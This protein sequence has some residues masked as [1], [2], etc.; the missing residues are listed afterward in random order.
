MDKPLKILVVDDIAQIRAL[1]R[2]G[3]QA[4][5]SNVEITEAE[6]LREARHA[7]Q[8]ASFDAIITDCGF[9]NETEVVRESGNRNGV[10]LINE[11]RQRK[12]GKTNA[13]APIAFNSAE[14]TPAKESGALQPG[15][16]TKCFKKGSLYGSLTRG[17]ATNNFTV[18]SVA[19]PTMSWLQTELTEEKVSERRKS[20]E[21]AARGNEGVSFLSRFFGVGS[22][23]NR[24]SGK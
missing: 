2:E 14:I 10:V 11:I 20:L 3:I 21:D 16:N 12:Y 19:T 7:L 4:T 23:S 9:P 24:A 18:G 22:K 1:F 8:N 17:T 6:N 13:L 5:F 15:G